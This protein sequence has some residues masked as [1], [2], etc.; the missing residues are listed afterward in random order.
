MSKF[1][2]EAYQGQLYDKDRNG[3]TLTEI[4]ELSGV[5]DKSLSEWFKRFDAQYAQASTLDL[6]TLHRKNADLRSVFQ[7][8]EVELFLLQN[9]WDM[10][11]ISEPSRITCARRVLSRYG[12]NQVCR[13]LRIRKSNLYYH[14]FRRPELTSYEKRD[15]ELRPAIQKIC[16]ANPKRIGAE[17]IRQKL[18]EQG[19]TV[20][21]KKML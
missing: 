13:T 8:K 16:E 19:F 9:E 17:R 4:C 3:F 2:V 20:C 11:G 18:V 21:K 15:L 12:P 5:T 14:A 1:Y 6:K 7:Q 10:A